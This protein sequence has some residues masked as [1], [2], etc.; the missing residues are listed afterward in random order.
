MRAQNRF[1]PEKED[2]IAV[3]EKNELVVRSDR[4]GSKEIIEPLV[5]ILT[6]AINELATDIHLDPFEQGKHVRYRVDGVIHEKPALPMALR[7]RLLNQVKVLMNLDIDKSFV[8]EEGFISLVYG[9]I[10]HDVRVTIAPIGDREAIH[11]RFLSSSRN[12]L[13]FESLG[14][15]SADVEIVQRVIEAPTGI[16]LVAGGT[17]SGKTTTLYSLANTLKGNRLIVT[18]IEDPVEFRLSRVRQLEVSEKHGFTMY[19]GLRTLLRMD[20]DVIIIGEIRDELSATTAARAGLSGQLVMATIHARSAAMAVDALNNMD[21]P[22]YVIGGALR[23]IIQQNLVLRLCRQCAREI[24][25]SEEGRSLFASHQ[26]PVPSA[27]YEA[28][29]CD[30]CKG[31]GH[32]GRVAVFGLTPIDQDLGQDI[33]A[34]LGARELSARFTEVQSHSLAQDVLRKVAD[35]IVSLDVAQR[36]VKGIGK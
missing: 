6:Q 26:V 16:I 7:Q 15:S 29:G 11:F 13:D 4:G 24:A 9:G 12:L 28:L 25:L 30:A 33:A 19:E 18:S 10:Q 20:P 36:F 14:M 17:G 27:V 3:V 5:G 35:G 8:P 34:G 31:Y 23:L 1:T 22:R 2:A 32:K 21:V